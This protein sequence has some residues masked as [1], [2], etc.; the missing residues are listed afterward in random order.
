VI[1]RKRVV[2]RILEFRG[3]GRARY[4]VRQRDVSNPKL[5]ITDSDV[6]SDYDGDTIYADYT[7]DEETGAVT[8]LASYLPGVGQV[9]EATGAVYYYHADH[10]GSVCVVTTCG[11]GAGDCVPGEAG[12]VVERIVHT[13][14]GE[15][16]TRMGIAL[17]P[18][19]YLYA[20]AWGY[21]SDLGAAHAG[22][23][24]GD[25]ALPY[26]HLGFRWYDP[27]SGR[28]LQRDPIGI[29]DGLNVY[30]YVGNNP[31]TWIDP[32]GLG[33]NPHAID[34]AT[35][36][37]ARIA[38][39]SSGQKGGRVGTLGG[40]AGPLQTASVNSAAASPYP[41][42]KMYTPDQQALIKLAK[43]LKRKG[44]TEAEARQLEE[45]AREYGLRYKGPEVHPNRPYG[46]NPHSHLGPVGH[47]PII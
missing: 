29:L 1:R 46:R 8:A 45:W 2:D 32:L 38:E 25:T 39:T 26:Q 9:D 36:L 10:L 41:P 47:I 30:R 31:L 24:P 3:S 4:L 14:F 16:G 33:M 15:P 7:V 5:L 11:V 19:R 34:A 20:G 28:F 40:T 27:A 22:G 17:T 37:G 23:S 13:A 21:E 6:W 43:E 35:D 12:M 44:M 18:T 42:C